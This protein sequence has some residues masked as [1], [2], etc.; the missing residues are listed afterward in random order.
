[1]IGVREVASSNL[2]VP[3]NKSHFLNYLQPPMLA[4]Y[5]LSVADLWQEFLG[6]EDLG[7]SCLSRIC[8]KPQKNRTAKESNLDRWTDRTCQ[9]RALGPCI[10]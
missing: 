1:L 3:T 9:A 7:T 10:L 6:G 8:E 5:F 4:A 2:A